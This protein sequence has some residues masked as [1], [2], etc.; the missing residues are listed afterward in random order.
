VVAVATH[1]NLAPN[2]FIL[3]TA[4]TVLSQENIVKIFKQV[5][6]KGEEERA[7]GRKGTLALYLYLEKL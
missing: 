6:K 5:E 3:K 4:T 1:F 2:S 7:K